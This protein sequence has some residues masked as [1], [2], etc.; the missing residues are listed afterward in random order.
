MI[1]K[2][3]N[4]AF[5][6]CFAHICATGI[7]TLL[8]LEELVKTYT[9]EMRKDLEDCGV[10]ASEDEIKAYLSENYAALKRLHTKNNTTLK[11]CI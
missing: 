4:E 9:G 11:L 6:H 7:T 10:T 2:N 3:R 1:N 5:K 8:T